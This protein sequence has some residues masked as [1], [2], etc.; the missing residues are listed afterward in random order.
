VDIAT[1]QIE[2]LTQEIQFLKEQIELMRIGVPADPAAEVVRTKHEAERATNERVSIGSE[3]LDFQAK[4]D[5]FTPTISAKL[6]EIQ[7]ADQE[8]GLDGLPPFF[9]WPVTG[10]ISAGYLDADYERVFHIPHRA[11]DIA[12]PQGTAIKAITDGIVFAVRDG[13]AMGYSY[14]LIGHQSGFASLYG[15]VSLALVKAGDTVHLGQ[16]IGLSGGQPG[17]HG[18]GHMTTGPHLHLEM[19]K[20]GEHVNPFTVLPKK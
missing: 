3:I 16:T 10:P 9:V 20:G 7:K 15:H 13:G 14:I 1:G 2:K 8:S 17:T 5:A 19:M 12:V 11:I 18:A 6:V 4:I